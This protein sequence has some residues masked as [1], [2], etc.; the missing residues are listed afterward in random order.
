MRGLSV[1]PNGL[2]G[3]G[4]GH[5][6]LHPRRP[7][8]RHGMNNVRSIS[9]GILFYP[10]CRTRT[11]VSYCSFD[12]CSS[13]PDQEPVEGLCCRSNS[14]F[15][16]RIRC[17]WAGGSA[18]SMNR[19]GAGQRFDQTAFHCNSRWQRT[20]PGLL[21]KSLFL[22]CGRA[23]TPVPTGNNKQ[24][25]KGPASLL[26]RNYNNGVY[27]QSADGSENR[28]HLTLDPELQNKARWAF[29]RCTGLF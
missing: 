25:R 27:Q 7:W 29:G 4:Y 10:R 12:G 28:A 14:G 18:A 19:Q 17:C 24:L 22:I 5:L 21:T 15:R 13:R 1:R 3:K 9:E 16:C 20:V 26:V 11:S 23:E 6:R 2:K 8:C